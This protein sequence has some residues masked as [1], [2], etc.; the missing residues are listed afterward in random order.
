VTQAQ[1]V[2][3][4]AGVNPCRSVR[5]CGAAAT[6][7]TTAVISNSSPAAPVSHVVLACFPFTTAIAGTLP[8][9]EPRCCPT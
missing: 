7:I 5:T 6:I 1:D 4:S 8:R 3:R 9:F 2:S